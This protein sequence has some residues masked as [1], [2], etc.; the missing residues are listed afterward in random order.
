[1]SIYDIP[2]V[3][4]TVRN[5]S[6]TLELELVGSDKSVL[7]VGCATGY[8]A[9]ALV[10]RGCAVTGVEYDPA[11]A[12]LARPSLSELVVADLNDADL[13]EL[14]AGKT[15]E[16]TGGTADSARRARDLVGDP[17]CG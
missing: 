7:D 15:F 13:A 12:E 3:D 2:A 16:K 8:L 17:L 5:S 1:M 4:A 11:A 6:Q 9:R 10:D 14:L